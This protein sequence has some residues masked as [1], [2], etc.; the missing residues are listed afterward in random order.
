MQKL[1]NLRGETTFI[2]DSFDEWEFCPSDFTAESIYVH[3]KDK[4]INATF[5]CHGCH[6]SWGW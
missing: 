5:L 4:K 1:W 2:Y 3:V 6:T